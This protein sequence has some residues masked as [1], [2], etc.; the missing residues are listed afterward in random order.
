VKNNRV[1]RS[2]APFSDLDPQ[3]FEWVIEHMEVERFKA[4][5][6]VFHHGQKSLEKLF[7]VVEGLAEVLVENDTG[8]EYVV[9]TR[10]PGD[11]FG[12]T[13]ILSQKEYAGSIKVV[14]SLV[15]M[16][17]K[18]TDFE[19]LLANDLNFANFFSKILTQRARGLYEELYLE[20]SHL[21]TGLDSR[22]FR[23]KVSELMTK[24]AVSCDTSHNAA[25][26]GEIMAKHNIGSLLVLAG[27]KL[28]GI[29]TEKDLV[30]KVVAAD[31]K[32]RE[33]GVSAVMD[34]EVV[35]LPPD[36]FFYQALLAMVRNRVK[37]VVVTDGEDISG[38]VSLRDLV[39]ARS[40]GALTIVDRIET[41]D[42]LDALV[43]ARREA[44][45]VL[46][47]L[48]YEKA[49]IPEICE[50]I[51]ELNDRLT[52]KIIVLAEKEME[53][54]GW[55]TPPVSYCHIVM[56]SGGRKEQ[57]FRTD[58]DN[59]IIYADSSSKQTA[60]LEKYFLNL[61][62]KIVSGLERCGFSRCNG[63]VMANSPKWCK[64]VSAWK[65]DMDKWVLEPEGQK[66]RDLTIFLDFRPVYGLQDMAYELRRYIFQKFNQMPVVLKYLARDDLEHG[67]PISWLGNVI[68]EKSRKHRGQ[69]NLK[70]AASVHLV[71][72]VRIF[73][74]RENIDENSTFERIT[75]LADK[76]VLSSDDSEIFNT[77]Y[78]SLL[79]LRLK[80]NLTKANKGLVPDNYVNPVSLSKRE[81]TV[82]KDAFWAVKKLQHLTGQALQVR[83]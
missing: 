23:K 46:T 24:E 25:E 58:Q 19:Y 22:P 37:H 61:G 65:K 45:H 54:E 27:D 33:L 79:M 60:S 17:L 12:E 11:F 16:T 55:G 57:L 31:Q 43:A 53:Q 8:N 63:G 50:V 78:Q 67:V 5:E 69:L 18:N 39:K 14:S 42:N 7:F 4:E 21:A 38:V 28:V 49:P 80:G 44:D 41:E 83:K 13:G 15:C 77:A 74:L 3:T 56:G 51:T 76:G 71:D 40:S 34:T 72:C 1:V 52:R 36:A 82:L 47:A 6:Y 32:P 75:Q 2:S 26:A 9:G 73:A 81:R 70:T 30:T 64:S 59:G 62:E 68:T 66:L 10:K 48:F 35:T 20:H 29:I